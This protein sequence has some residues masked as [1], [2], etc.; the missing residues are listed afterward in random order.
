MEQDVLPGERRYVTR[1]EQAQSN[2]ADPA[3]IAKVTDFANNHGLVVVELARSGAASSFPVPPLVLA[4]RLAQNCSS[5]RPE[6]TFRGRTGELTI[7]AALE[8]IVEGVFG[9]DDRPQAK[10]HFQCHPDPAVQPLAAAPGT[11]TPFTCAAV[12]T[13]LPGWMARGRASR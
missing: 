7:P 2:G 1:E 13:S 12:S 3:D 4:R 8:G 9:L 11:F 5:T 6:G 10:P